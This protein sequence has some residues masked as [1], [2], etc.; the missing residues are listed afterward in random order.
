VVVGIAPRALTHTHTR[1][2]LSLL[3]EDADALSDSGPDA[4]TKG[5]PIWRRTSIGKILR[6]EELTNAA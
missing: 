5:L 2:I 4:S 1:D 3:V 6:P